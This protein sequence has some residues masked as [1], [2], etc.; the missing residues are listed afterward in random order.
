MNE[1]IYSAIQDILDDLWAEYDPYDDYHMVQG[2]ENAL[3]KLLWLIEENYVMKH[4]CD[5]LCSMYGCPND[6]DWKG[7]RK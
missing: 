2:K 5:K 4:T 6:P 1:E 3:T 7:D